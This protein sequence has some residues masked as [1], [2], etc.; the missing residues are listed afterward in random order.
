MTTQQE[1]LFWAETGT[2]ILFSEGDPFKG[3]VPKDSLV[4][5]LYNRILQKLVEDDSPDLD[6]EEFQEVLAEIKSSNK[7]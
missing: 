1:A 5:G 6:E 2:E 4:K 3:R 7:N